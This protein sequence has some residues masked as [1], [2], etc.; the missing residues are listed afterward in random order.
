M[1]PNLKNPKKNYKNS[2]F[3]VYV[4]FLINVEGK[5]YGRTEE[6]KEEREREGEE[7]RGKK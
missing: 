4:K 3:F 2:F 5:K 1:S 6:R 7:D